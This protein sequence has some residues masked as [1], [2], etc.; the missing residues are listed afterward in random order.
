MD[1]ENS[2]VFQQLVKEWS[3]HRFDVKDIARWGYARLNGC[4]ED[5]NESVMFARELEYI[6]AKTYDVLYPGLKCRELIPV[7]REVPPGADQHTYQQ[8]DRVGEAKEVVDYA[9]DF[10]TV[11]VSGKEFQ[12]KIVSLGNGYQYSTQDMRAAAMAK[13]PL[14]AMKARAARLAMEEK[15]ERIAATGSDARGITGLLNAPNVLLT[16]DTAYTTAM[17]SFNGSWDTLTDS[18][19]DVQKIQEDV[20]NMRNFIWQ[21]TKTVHGNSNLTLLLPT[22]LFAALES[23]PQSPTFKDSTIAEFLLRTVPG[24]SSIE[25]WLQC[26]TGGAS[27]V[28]RVM[29]YEKDPDICELIIPQEFEQLPP[30]LEGMAFK[31]FCHMRTGG[32]SVRRPRACLYSDEAHS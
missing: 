22:D 26:D 7:N 18:S 29:M 20:R 11:E 32:V 31:I 25:Y 4:R 5:A 12:N 21:S 1:L 6:Y 27:G 19:T 16:T 30:Q 17:N 10:P 24:L 28:P 3:G 15:L 14:D 13:K 8:Y 2:P 23:K 9:K